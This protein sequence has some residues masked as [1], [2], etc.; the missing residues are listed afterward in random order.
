M[1]ES[2]SYFQLVTKP[3]KCR[4]C[5][6]A[7]MEVTYQHYYTK[8]KNATKQP[9]QGSPQKKVPFIRLGLSWKKQRGFFSSSGK[10][11]QA[12]SGI[13]GVNTDDDGGT[14]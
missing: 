2:F 14:L 3:L 13:P 6:R 7:E 10:P 9:R 1:T 11:L 5:S 4:L 12:V 8:K